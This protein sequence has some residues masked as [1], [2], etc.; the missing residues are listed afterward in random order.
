MVEFAYQAVIYNKKGDLLCYVMTRL[1]RG[2]VKGWLRW[3][4]MLAIVKF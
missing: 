3:N 2:G 1:L 4:F